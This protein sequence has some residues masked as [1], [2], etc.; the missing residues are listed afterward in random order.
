MKYSIALALA[1]TSLFA[2]PSFAQSAGIPIR[3]HLEKAG[4]VTLVIDDAEGKR[5]RNLISEKALPAGDNTAFWDGYDEGTRRAGEGNPWERDLIRRRVSPGSYAVRGLAHDRLSLSYEFSV[6]SPGTPPWK[7]KDGSGGWLADHSPAGDILFLPQSAPSPNGK[8]QASFL[9]CATS[10][11]TSEAFVWL[12]AEGRRLYGVNT[13]F[14]GGTHLARDIGAKAIADTVAYTFISGERDPDNNNIEVRAIK[15]SG[16]IV[17]AALLK[18]PMELKKTT[19]PPFKTVAEAYGTNGLAVFNGIVVFSITRQNR[20]I[21]ANARNGKILGEASVESPRGLCFDKL[22]RLWVITRNLV[23]RYSAAPEAAR[24]YGFDLTLSGLEEPHRLALDSAGQLYVADWGRSHQVKAFSPQGK[25]VQTF[26]KRSAGSPLGIYDPQTFSHPC[27]LAVDG[28]G[29]LWVSEAE[30]APRRLSVWDTRDGTLLRAT[31]G[32]SQYGGGGKIDPGDPTRLYMDPVW[33][34]AGVTWN[35]DW[36]A[37]TAYPYSIFWRPDKPHSDP[38]PP[39]TPETMF[40]RE[41]YRYLTNS[42]DSFE[43]YNQDRG[44]G[45]WRLDKDEIARPVAIIGNGADLIH[46]GWG[47]PLRHRNEIAALWKGLDPAT[48]LFVWTDKNNNQIAEPDEVQF[49]QVLSPK[50]GE[51]LRDVGLGA[52]TAPDLSFVTAWGVHIAAPKIDA[53]GVLSYDLSRQDFIGDPTIHS[54]RVPGGDRTLYLRVDGDGLTGSRK[55]GKGFWSYQSAAGGQAIPGLL[56]EPTRLIGLPV[57]PRDGE[58]GP[59]FAYNSDKGGIYLMTMD[60]L[61]LQTLGGDARVTP[62]WRRPASL[63]RRGMP[64]EDYSYGEEHFHP[65]IAQEEKSGEIDLVVGHEHSSIVRLRGLETVRRFVA[66]SVQVSAESLASLSE[67][68]IE[69]ARKTG[70]AEAT[71]PLLAHDPKPDTNH[72]DWAQAKWLPLDERASASLQLTNETLY[73]A[74]KTGDPNAIQGGKGDYRYQFKRG[75][76][77][78]LMI[79]Y[80]GSDSGRDSP[81]SGDLR[82]LVTRVDGKTRAVLY[83]AVV[84]NAP[85]TASVLFD[86]P[87]GKTHFDQVADISDSVKLTVSGHGEFVVSAPLAVLGLPPLKT[88]QELLGDIGLLRGDGAQTTQRLYWNNQDVGLVSDVPGEA[89]LRPRNWGVW[90]VRQDSKNL[91]R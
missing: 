85:E 43:R 32:S 15:R 87:I 45:I 65:T 13:G 69:T 9:V 31:Y 33:S 78:D 84:P 76:A 63:T 34:V 88:G 80:P 83:R 10:G 50:G 90:R 27:G 59:L 57:T 6:N 72:R 39:A 49:T 66:E 42:Y 37:G 12:S 40:R 5:I 8:G 29:K 70:R 86:S 23:R 67:T 91:N 30:N 46:P 60:G 18:F 68:R 64:V 89:R 54:E 20:L 73:A 4:Y 26:G 52:Q 7:T 21:F 3:F 2:R 11:E 71:L 36:K 35:M 77:L 19:L 16:V 79:G 14:W 51:P 24:L 55:D 22:G 38:M 61:F 56:T 25:L 74:W 28:A 62:L 41:G 44:V 1:A 48:V 75:G 81:A 58:A 17:S 47:L 53:R 82:L